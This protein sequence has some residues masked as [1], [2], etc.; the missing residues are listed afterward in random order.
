[1]FILLSF[2]IAYYIQVLLS[3]DTL[4]HLHFS[5]LVLGVQ[6]VRLGGKLKIGVT[7]LQFM[8]PAKAKRPGFY[9]VSKI[10]LLIVE[11]LH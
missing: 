2:D 5:V 7:E 3:N 10:L 9:T 11:Y 8:S 1:M 4:D 6:R